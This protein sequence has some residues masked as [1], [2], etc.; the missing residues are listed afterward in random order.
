MEYIAELC[1]LSKRFI[2]DYPPSFYPELMHKHGRPYTCLLIDSH[3]DYFICIPF[4]SSIKHK[5][6]F[7]FTRTIRS[8]K[9][10]SGLDYSKI[11]VIKN[12]DYLDSSASPVVDQDEYAEMMKKLS[13]IVEEAN[14]YVNTYIKH[15]S[16][17]ALIHPKAFSRKYQYSTLSYFHD[18][19]GISTI[20]YTG[21]AS[22]YPLT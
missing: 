5:N 18:I 2:Q 14:N 4:R 1:L 6:A 12:S 7:M 16:G 11:A 9:T 21:A 19:L 22:N 13:I 17:V 10:K 15:V 3:S 20:Q 8:Q